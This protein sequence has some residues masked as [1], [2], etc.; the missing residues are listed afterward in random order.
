[1]RV[2]GVE[3]G[4]DTEHVLAMDVSLPFSRYDSSHK[5]VDYY[6]RAIQRLAA[7][8]GVRSA[9]V[10]NGMPLEGETWVDGIARGE[11]QHDRDKHVS[12]N[13]RYVSPGFLATMGTPLRAGRDIA[14][15][16][17][18][19][20]RVAV[21]SERAARVLWPG[22]SP[23]GK[24][25]DAGPGDAL[26]QVVG[27]AADVRAERLE[28]EATVVVYL[29]AWEQPQWSTTLVVRAAGDP[30]ALAPAVRTA[31]REVDALVPVPK[32]R[33]ARQIVAASVA[34]RR[35]QVAL[36][37]LLAA[38]AFV[39]ASVGIYGVI[40]QSLA[41]RRGEI[42]VRLA[43]GARPGDVHR[44]VLREGM[45][46]VALGLAAGITAALALGRL[47]ASQ[48][49]E[50]RP[51]DPATLAAVVLLL[52]GVAAVACTIPAR[53]ATGTG[54]TQLLKFE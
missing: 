23:I 4:F 42:G 48:L 39:T 20:A 21:V 34:A 2:L 30:A 11:D 27:V 32:V 12:A 37:L 50:V 36:L 52:G 31:L 49:Y 15:T 3:R 26:A 16:D 9:G 19:S 5:V 43:L 45:I 10:T 28:N 38:M 40:A 53:R 8:P 35:F 22:E 7:V 29:P 24:S 6:D 41:S 25:M 13:I 14:A 17:R 44:L 1:V 33:T 18:G 46:P 47:V 51:S 54:L